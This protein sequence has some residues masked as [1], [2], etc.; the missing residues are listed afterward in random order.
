MRGYEE[1]DSLAECRFLHRIR[2]MLDRYTLKIRC[3]KNKKEG[4]DDAR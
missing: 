1:S 3:A 4:D 2:E